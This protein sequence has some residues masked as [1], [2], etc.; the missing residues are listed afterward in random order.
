MLCHDY[1]HTR[2]VMLQNVVKI[3]HTDYRVILCD[4]IWHFEFWR[5][6]FFQYYCFDRFF[7]DFFVQIIY[8]SSMNCVKTTLFSVI[9]MTFLRVALGDELWGSIIWCMLLYIKA[10]HDTMPA[11]RR[12]SQQKFSKQYKFKYFI[13]GSALSIN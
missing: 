10:D 11:P 12:V 8:I 5:F 9:I 1:Y 6:L 7:H 13:T 4:V 3:A 2:V